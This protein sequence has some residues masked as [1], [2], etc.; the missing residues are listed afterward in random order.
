MDAC[1]FLFFVFGGPG[2]SKGKNIFHMSFFI[3]HFS[4]KAETAKSPRTAE[5]DA[6]ERRGSPRQEGLNEK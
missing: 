4:L 2:F 1:P 5:Q 3:S 6:N